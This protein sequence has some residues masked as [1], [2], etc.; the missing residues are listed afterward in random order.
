[1]AS[2]SSKADVNPSLSGKDSPVARAT[3]YNDMVFLVET[4]GSNHHTIGDS[5]T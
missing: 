5:L 4:R 3:R 2:L 1:M